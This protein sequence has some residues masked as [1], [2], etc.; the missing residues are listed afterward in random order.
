M[1]VYSNPNSN[2]AQEAKASR[3][4]KA[5]QAKKSHSADGLKNSPGS[6]LNGVH[7][8]ISERAREMAEA[9]KIA[10][11]APDVREDKIAELKKRIASGEYKIDPGKIADRLV[12]E[13]L[14]TASLK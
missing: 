9:K 12:D 13:H 7:A 10:G 8:S 14:E 2:A 3:S 11:A 4:E 6:D 1:K 5:G